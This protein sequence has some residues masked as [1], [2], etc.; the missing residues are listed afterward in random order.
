[1]FSFNCDNEQW[2]GFIFQ[3]SPTHLGSI[4][5]QNAAVILIFN[6]CYSERDLNDNLGVIFNGCYSERDFNDN[7]RV[8]FNGCYSERDLNDNL[9]VILV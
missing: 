9:T 1:M 2:W 8:I 7:L 3:I 6:G 4:S 5:I